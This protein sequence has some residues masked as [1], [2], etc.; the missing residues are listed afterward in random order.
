MAMEAKEMREEIENQTVDFRQ[1][2]SDF[3]KIKHGSLMSEVY[4]L[5]V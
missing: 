1:W 4:S 3:S 2:T 5:T